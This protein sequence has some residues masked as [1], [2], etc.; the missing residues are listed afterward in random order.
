MIWAAVSFHSFFFFC[1]LYTVSP[2]S[3]AKNIN[4]LILVLSIWWCS[5]VKSSLVLLEDGVCYDQC[6]LLAKP[7][8]AFALLHFVLQDQTRLLLQVSL[9]FLLLNSSP[10]WWKGFCACV[11]VLVV[12]GLTVFMKP[13]SF[14][15]FYISVWG[16]HLD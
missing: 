2:S 9:D 6:G 12:E 1:W 7:L 3:A 4:N 10:L 8:L 15:F 14:S 5:Y 13:F 16:I 11:C